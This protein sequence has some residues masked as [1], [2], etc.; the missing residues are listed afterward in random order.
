MFDE[1]FLQKRRI[2]MKT[3]EFVE[4]VSVL[5]NKRKE[6]KKRTEEVKFLREILIKTVEFVESVLVLGNKKKEEKKRTEEV[7]F[8]EEVSVFL[9][10]NLVKGYSDLSEG[11][12]SI[13]TPHVRGERAQKCLKNT[14]KCCIQCI[15]ILTILKNKGSIGPMTHTALSSQVEQITQI[16]PQITHKVEIPP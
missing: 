8:L 5:G 7:K 13:S 6:E 1:N 16:L 4:S 12:G 2:L 10:E 11:S 9:L 15:L 3:F 14:Q